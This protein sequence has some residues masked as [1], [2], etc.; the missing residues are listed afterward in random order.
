M[1][2]YWHAQK[3]AQSQ[4]QESNE[5]A[6]IPE[7]SKR[8][9]EELAI[10]AGI[11]YT[12]DMEEG[13]DVNEIEL[14]D[15]FVGSFHEF[16]ERHDIELKF[17]AGSWQTFSISEPYDLVLTS[18]TVYDVENLP[19]LVKL[20]KT[21]SHSDGESSTLTLVA[22]KRV[23]FGVGGG[24]VAFKAAVSDT[25]GTIENIWSGG[26][27]VERTVMRASWKQQSC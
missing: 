16:L 21:A 7:S 13:P 6:S 1:L 24:E 9:K 8:S 17:F 3:R 27:G 26:Q 11:E 15:E 18:E 20:L 22:C 25:D 2:A 19:S 5:L 4:G 14:S 12:I 10:S 23:Y